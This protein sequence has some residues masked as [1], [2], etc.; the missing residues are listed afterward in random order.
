MRVLFLCTGNYYRS[1][2]AEELLHYH[3][4]RV[5]LSI[6]C[7]SAGLGNIPNPSNPGPI[8][9]VALEYLQARGIGSLTRARHPKK[10]A[11]S[12]IQAAD[13]IVCMNEREHRATFEKQARLFLDHKQ[14]VYWHVPDLEEDPE[15]VGPGL[16]E[17]EVRGLLTRLKDTH[18]V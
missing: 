9:I 18:L 7:Y 11:P 16:I 8:G 12:D 4:K 3:A 10:C 14:I 15:L 6:E 5:D 1:R 2:L 17:G 13:I